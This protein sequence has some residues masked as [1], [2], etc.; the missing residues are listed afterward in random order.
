[1][2]ELKATIGLSN[3]K[4]GLKITSMAG[5]K[6]S[7][8]PT[9]QG[10][11]MEQT[12]AGLELEATDLDVYIRVVLPETG[13]PEK[14]IVTPA[15]KFHAWTKL[16]SGDDVTLT[17]N[18]ARATV[19]CGRA[20]AVLPLIAANSWPS[21]EIYNLKAEGIT[22]T[23]GVL[24]RALDFAQIAVSKEESRYTLN[25]VL[26]QGDGMQLQVVATD[27]HCLLHYT[28]P[29]EEKMTLLLPARLVKILLPLLTEEDG[30]VDLAFNDSHMLATIDA[31]TK[32]YVGSPAMKGSFPNWQAVMPSDKRTDI[33][34]PVA[35]LSQSLERCALLSEDHVCAVDLS[36][37]GGELTLH[38]ASA[39]HGE[40]DETVTY[41]GALKHP[42]KT[43]VNA[44]FLHALTRK[45]TG[46]LAISIPASSDK[47]LYLKAAPHEGETLGYVVM[48][49]RI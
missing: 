25:G 44:E 29:C 17:A 48:P 13:G 43:R 10:V 33:E 12:A 42:F 11:R 38:S 23:Q 40:A 45:L 32:L 22:L 9:L 27:G 3:L 26:L 15:E 30:G 6:G 39:V 31:E 37:E 16:L 46:E 5:S 1:M 41:K 2:E 24:A 47:P 19:K 28:V 8:I 14:P 4:H 20:R 21:S 36:F 34:V 49:M 35:E 18:G 7:L